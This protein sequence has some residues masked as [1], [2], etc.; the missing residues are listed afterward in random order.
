[1]VDG[2]R[3]RALCHSERSEESPPFPQTRYVVPAPAGIY[4]LNR[5][6]K[7]LRII[8]HPLYGLPACAGAGTTQVKGREIPRCARND[9]GCAGMTC[10]SPRGI[11]YPHQPQ[12][13]KSFQS[14]KSRFRQPCL[15]GNDAKRREGEGNNPLILSIPQIPVQTVDPVQTALPARE[16]RKTAGRGREKSFNPFNPSNPGSDCRPRFRQPRV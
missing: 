5:D 8:P 3:L 7:D 16:R 4:R 2:G 9:S 14:L 1:M 12:I 13:L 15:R 6:W 10:L 11:V